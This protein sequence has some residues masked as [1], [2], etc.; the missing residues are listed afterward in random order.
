[1]IMNIMTK[2]Y[3]V[4]A[5]LIALIITAGC[6][7]DDAADTR[8]INPSN[9]ICHPLD[10]SSGV[11]YFP[12]Y[13]ADFGNAL[14]SWKTKHPDRI[15]TAISPNDRDTYGYT[16]GYFVNSELRTNYTGVCNDV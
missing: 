15:V 16:L 9:E 1:M 8:L 4:G 5:I 14:V 12:C 2:F 7:V 3:V 6:T 13:E 11:Y 10:Y